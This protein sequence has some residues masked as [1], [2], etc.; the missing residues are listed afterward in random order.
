LSSINSNLVKDDKVKST[1]GWSVILFGS[2]LYA[3]IALTSLPQ[4]LII[5]E[6]VSPKAQ[7]MHSP[8]VG[9]N[10]VR[11]FDKTKTVRVIQDHENLEEIKESYLSNPDVDFVEV[12]IPMQHFGLSPQDQ[13][14][15]DQWGFKTGDGGAN[16]TRAW[17]VTK[18][19]NQIIVAVIDT[20]I[21]SH[22]DLNEKLLPGYN[23]ISDGQIAGNGVGRTNDPTDLGD[24]PAEGD[25]CFNG[26]SHQSSSWHGTH[27]AGTIAASTNNGL[28]VAGGDWNARI[29]PV[30]VLGK[31]GGYMSDIADG[32]RW[33]AG[34]SVQGVPS[35]PH[36]AQ[37]INL[38]LGGFGPC[39][40]SMQTAVDFALSQGAVVVVAAGNDAVN[41]NQQAVTPAN[42]NGVITVGASNRFGS[43]TGYSNFGRRIDL[44]APGGDQNGAIL[45]THNM[46]QQT[47]GNPGYRYLTGTSMA[48]PHVSAVASLILSIN[49]NFPPLQVKDM[50]IRSTKMFPTLSCDE[51]RCGSGL[52]DAQDAISLA[53]ASTVDQSFGVIAPI[54]SG[55]SNDQTHVTSS[56]KGGGCGTIDMDGSGGGSGGSG[57]FLLTLM[58]LMVVALEKMKRAK[59]WIRV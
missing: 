19:S 57:M 33:A 27:V 29:L 44:M 42:C 53:Q 25:P 46:G 26:W 35:N 40:Q 41:L 36:P 11:R 52:L 22:P 34:G 50:I 59:A 2:L 39:S 7:A 6:K 9:N 38:S 3:P 58:G 13:F 15:N 47:Q 12:D 1:H 30:R 37:V 16:F 8:I 55:G 10:Q 17:E 49:R 28:G 48:A 21:T 31:C 45:S 51:D 24:F 32:V 23:F 56:G 4:R 18:G 54:Q 20:G 5:H 14:F 43:R